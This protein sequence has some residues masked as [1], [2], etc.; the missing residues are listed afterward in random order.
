VEQTVRDV[1]FLTYI[2]FSPYNEASET[3]SVTVS[4]HEPLNN[5]VMNRGIFS[6]WTPEE[7]ESANQ[8]VRMR[9]LMVALGLWGA[10]AVQT[11]STL[12]AAAPQPGPGYGDYRDYIYTSSAVRDIALGIFAGA[13]IVLSLVAV[14]LCPPLVAAMPAA[15]GAALVPIATAIGW[16]AGGI[17]M[18]SLALAG[19]ADAVTHISVPGTWRT[20][21]GGPRGG[22]VIA[23][24]DSGLGYDLEVKPYSNAPANHLLGFAAA[25]DLPDHDSFFSRNYGWSLP[26]DNEL[27]RIYYLQLMR[28]Q[29]PHSRFS[30]IPAAAGNIMWTK[31]GVQGWADM[32][33][34]LR[35]SD[36]PRRA[37]DIQVFL[38]GNFVPQSVSTAGVT[39]G[40]CYV[41]KITEDAPREYPYR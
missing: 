40:A 21:P 7:G 17:A 3:F 32:V 41:R 19:A 4:G 34:V 35:F 16:A 18:G 28:D 29:L 22:Y 26:T 6:A 13:V 30:A 24:E 25:R 27:V 12:A 36:P 11:D 2:S 5:M 23:A 33:W 9:N 10:L 39:G 15:Y 37:D 14:V 20:G 1:D 38:S 8:T 31:T